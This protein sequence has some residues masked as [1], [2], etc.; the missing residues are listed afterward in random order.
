VHLNVGA[1]HLEHDYIKLLYKFNY[2]KSMQNDTGH[3]INFLDSTLCLGQLGCIQRNLVGSPKQGMFDVFPY[4]WGM[5]P[6]ILDVFPFVWGMIPVDT[7]TSRD[8]P[9]HTSCVPLP[10]GD[11]P[12]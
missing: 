8:D 12:S 11:D 7:L 1:R 3:V 6:D 5:M 10:L 9:R 4:V 2:Y